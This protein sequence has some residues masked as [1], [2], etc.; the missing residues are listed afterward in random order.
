M[1]STEI[2]IRHEL[3]LPILSAVRHILG[4]SK[5]AGKAEFGLTRLR[6]G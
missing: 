6:S 3:A 2:A 1:Q 4:I 5:Q